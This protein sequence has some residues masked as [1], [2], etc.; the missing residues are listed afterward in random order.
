[1]AK[2]S[3]ERQRDFRYKLKK[4]G[5]KQMLITVTKDDWDKGFKAGENGASNVPP[6]DVDELSWIS[7]YIEGKAKKENH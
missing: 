7:G 6:D 3:A 2:T 5:K 4:E 1:M